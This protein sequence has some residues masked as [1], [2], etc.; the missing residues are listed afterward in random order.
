MLITVDGIS[1]SLNKWSQFLGLHP[2]S[3]S[4]YYR[5]NGE[6]KTKERIE[7]YLKGEVPNKLNT[8]KKYK[9]GDIINNYEILEDFYDEYNIRKFKAKCLNCGFI[10]NEI[11]LTSIKYA[12]NCPNHR[13]LQQSKK[14]PLEHKLRVILTTIKRRCNS[15][16][17]HSKYY[18]DKNITICKEWLNNPKSFITWAIN[19]G[20]QEGLTIDRIDSNGNYCPE[21]CRWISLGDNTKRVHESTFI[22]V[23]GI[24]DSYRGWSKRLNLNEYTVKTWIRKLGREKTIEKITN[25]LNENNINLIN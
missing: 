19:N 22:T 9:I 24:T 17:R 21:N 3:L 4:G 6:G 2:N 20:Y 12:N 8:I 14:N 13:I 16:K 25:T 15:T 10:Y 18:K 5:E 1:K 11:S 23:N 7:K